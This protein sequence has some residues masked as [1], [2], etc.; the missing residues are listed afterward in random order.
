[1]PK[2]KKQPVPKHFGTL[3]E[4]GKFWDAHDLGD[5]WGQTQE[6]TMSFRLRRKRHLFSIEPGLAHKLH[7]AAEARGVSPENHR[8][9][10]AAG[11][12]R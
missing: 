7:A 6:V 9:S 1:M 12:A 5:Y 8:Q 2:N 10:V 4:A 11:N 3:E